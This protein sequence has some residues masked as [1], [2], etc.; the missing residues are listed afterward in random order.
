VVFG[1]GTGTNVLEKAEHALVA[2]PG[3]GGCAQQEC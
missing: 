1:R 2:V 3:Q